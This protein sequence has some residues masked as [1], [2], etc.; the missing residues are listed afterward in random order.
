[1]PPSDNFSNSASEIT[2]F[3]A[4]KAPMRSIALPVNSEPLAPWRRKP[5][6]PTR[7]PPAGAD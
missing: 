2:D 3:S 6:L 4:L 1:M 5:T 7:A